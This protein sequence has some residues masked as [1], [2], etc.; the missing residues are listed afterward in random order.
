MENVMGQMRHNRPPKFDAFTA[1]DASPD[2]TAKH[3]ALAPFD[4]A[5]RQADREWGVDRLPGLVSPDTAAKWGL[6]VAQ[7]NTAIA[8]GTVEDVT[9]RVGVCLRG[10]AKLAE[11][12]EA[13][14]A[15]RS[16]PQTWE[17]SDGDKFKFAILRDGKDWPAL[18]AQRPDLMFFTESEIVNAVKAYHRSI[19][20]LENIKKSFPDAKITATRNWEEE[21]GDS[22]PY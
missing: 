12:A 4:E 10:L 15:K 1:R 9:A 17:M 19:P 5:Q 22:L 16:N 20:A 7:L 21:I 2:D 13:R 3:Y 18:K 11:E 8:S 14:G 6:A